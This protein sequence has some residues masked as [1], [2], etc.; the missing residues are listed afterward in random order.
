MRDLLNLSIRRHRH[1]LGLTSIIGIGFDPSA[2]VYQANQTGALLSGKTFKNSCRY[3]AGTLL[4]GDKL[5][6]ASSKLGSPRF[7]A[8]TLGE[9]K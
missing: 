8:S 5:P 2:M 9:K 7:R 4:L 6:E 1:W 3:G